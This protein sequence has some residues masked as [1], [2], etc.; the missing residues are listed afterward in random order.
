M[1][2]LTP[3]F[4]ALIAHARFDEGGQAQACSLLYPSFIFPENDKD[5][6]KG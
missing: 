4:C 3:F 5:S 2:D 1:Q 6:K